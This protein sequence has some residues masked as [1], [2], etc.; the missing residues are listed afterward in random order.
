MAERPL[1]CLANSVQYRLVTPS[2]AAYHKKIVLLRGP[3]I[4][5]YNKLSWNCVPN[6]EAYAACPFAPTGE[7]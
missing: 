1:D 7:S 5:G 2:N 4:G 6:W 3:G